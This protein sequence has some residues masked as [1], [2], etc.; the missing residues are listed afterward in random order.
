MNRI[1]A[2]NRKTLPR[3]RLRRAGR[4][5]RM[6]AIGR[7]QRRP[8]TG[9]GN[10]SLYVRRLNSSRRRNGR[11]TSWPVRAGALRRVDM[12]L[13][14]L[15]GFDQHCNLLVEIVEMPGIEPGSERF[16]PRKSTSVVGRG[17]SS[18]GSRPTGTPCNQP[19]IFRAGSGVVRGTP[20]LS[21]PVRHPAES[22][23]GGRGLI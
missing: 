19:L 9:K 23:A 18:Q 14:S 13:M 21:R 22:G 15:K 17:S 8:N 16:D 12:F 7:S 3:R 1:C 10:S 2:T 20:P 5:A 4:R 6:N 11:V